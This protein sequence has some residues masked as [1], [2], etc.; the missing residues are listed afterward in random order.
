MPVTN[1]NRKILDLKRWEFAAPAPSGPS[2]GTFIASAK[3]IKQLQLY[4]TSSGVWLYSS[5]EDGWVQIGSSSVTGSFGSGI[6]GVASSFSSGSSTSSTL[7]ATG[8]TTSTI[9]TNQPLAWDLRGF[10]VHILSGPN[11]GLTLPIVSN[12]IGTNAIITVATQAA[13]FTS[14][15][16]YRLVTP[17]WYTS[18]AGGSNTFSTSW[19]KYDYA[20]N[21]WTTLGAT[22]G[23]SSVSNDARLINT[24]SWIENNY[25]SFA[26]GTATDGTATTLSNSSKSWTI[27][28]WTN[29]Q[30]RIVSGTGA[31]QIRTITSNTS[32]Q[33][34]VSTSWSTQPDNTSV[35]S[36]EGNDDFIYFMGN[37]STTLFRY[38]I[39]ANSWT[40]LSP[41]AARGGIPS[42]GM[43]AHWVWNISDTS[44]T[45]ENAIRNG[46]RIYS[47]RGGSSASLDYYDI[48][49]NTWVNNITYSP[50]IETFSSGSK[51]VYNGNFL[52]IQLNS[53]GRW[54][55]YDILRQQMEGWS[56]MLYPQGSAVV[57]DTAFDVVFR[58]GD[59]QIVFI[60]MI[61]NSLTIMLRQMVI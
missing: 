48:S 21:T 9:N 20:T 38:S 24:P 53:T 40:T 14:S 12:T 27:N 10:S 57:G 30:I 26:T 52:Y 22:G 39:S 2:S 15:T 54:F 61:L 46:Q 55:R 58:D 50:S 51:Y 3:H 4:V 7:T 37:S 17:T 44:W 41:T 19:R 8:G 43:S 45:S 47:F 33:I 56:T 34:T 11:A 16:I 18:L 49:A 13:A 31:G 36:I 6:C 23:P 28:Q 32:T 60:Y 29:Y 42:T 25:V 1:G 59:T 5:D 35:Y